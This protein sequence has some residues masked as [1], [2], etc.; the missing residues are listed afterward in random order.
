ML[1][2]TGLTA[3][4]LTGGQSQLPNARGLAYLITNQQQPLILGGTQPHKIVQVIAVELAACLSSVPVQSAVK[5]CDCLDQLT[6][7]KMQTNDCSPCPM[8]WDCYSELYIVSK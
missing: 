4:K 5:I 2:F 7:A 8:Y 1:E 3:A 6:A